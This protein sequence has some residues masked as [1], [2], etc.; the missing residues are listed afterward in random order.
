M[1]TAVCWLNYKQYMIKYE[2]HHP[3]LL[4]HNGNLTKFQCKSTFKCCYKDFYENVSLVKSS[5]FEVP[6]TPQVKSHLCNEPRTLLSPSVSFTT[7]LH[8]FQS[9][10]R[11]FALSPNPV[12]GLQPRGQRCCG[13][14]VYTL[15]RQGLKYSNGGGP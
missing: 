5:Y 12:L 14:S 2:N 10:L 11:L 7:G 13:C 8:S 3:F 1:G 9:P 15:L 6:V 4:Q